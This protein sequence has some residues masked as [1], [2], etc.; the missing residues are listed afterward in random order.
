MGQSG[1]REEEAALDERGE[2]SDVGVRS[3]VEASSEA[4]APG[5]AA[6]FDLFGMP[7]QAA[8]AAPKAEAR[9]KPSRA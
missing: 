4:K 5:E 9:A 3:G 8:P 7:V 1:T 6:Q 2:Q